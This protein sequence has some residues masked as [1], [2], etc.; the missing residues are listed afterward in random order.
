MK[1]QEIK[2]LA[3]SV[4]VR[5]LAAYLVDILLLF[6]AIIL[7]QLGLN[8]LTE[9][10]PMRLFT[11]GPRLGGWVWLSVSLP[12]YLYF[13]R[14]ESSAP[15]GTLGKRLLGLRVTD[16]AGKRIGFGRALIRTI[17]KLIPWEVTHLS[18][19][20]PTPIFLD[21]QGG[22]LPGLITANV[23][24]VVYLTVIA[25]TAGKRGIHDLVA[26]TMVLPRMIPWA[27]GEA[28]KRQEVEQN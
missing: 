11:T 18:L 2:T 20:L 13:A 4:L 21:R 15:G 27:A 22:F 7:T 12:T 8:A 14:S 23:L 3:Y 25:M 28:I 24:I 1:K 26:G 17:V 10:L 5:R 6:A 16:T 19:F 9:G